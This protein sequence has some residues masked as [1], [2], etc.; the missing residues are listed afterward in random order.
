MSQ[1]DS[2]RKI[3]SKFELKVTNSKQASV[4]L[5]ISLMDCDSTRTRKL[6][7]T[8]GHKSL[9]NSQLF[10]KNTHFSFLFGSPFRWC[11]YFRYCCYRWRWM[12][13]FFYLLFIVWQFEPD[14]I[15]LIWLFFVL[16]VCLSFAAGFCAN[17]FAHHRVIG[18]FHHYL[19]P[20]T[21]NRTNTQLFAHVNTITD[22]LLSTL[23]TKNTNHS[24]FFL[25]MLWLVFFAFCL[26]CFFLFNVLYSILF[27]NFC[28][29]S[30]VYVK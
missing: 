8:P 15:D 10:P 12:V 11:N 24:Y 25:L 5:I 16:F 13:L 17:A 29:N 3:T 20:N 18:Y 22:P 6:F 27:W 1:H 4:K 26:L 23:P 30:R 19:H 14:L 9:N 2:L 21:N 28:R 7:Q